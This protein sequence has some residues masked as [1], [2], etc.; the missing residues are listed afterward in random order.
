MDSAF[1]IGSIPSLKGILLSEILVHAREHFIT[2]IHQAYRNGNNFEMF[3]R[4]FIFYH[5]LYKEID[6]PP[7]NKRHLST[8]FDLPPPPPSK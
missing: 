3:R 1:C 5:I 6:N 2:Q 8:P 4:Q 7:Y